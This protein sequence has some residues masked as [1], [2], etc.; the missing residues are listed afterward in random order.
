MREGDYA[1]STVG[2]LAA[3]SSRPRLDKIKA[4]PPPAK[5]ERQSALTLQPA[6]TADRSSN[7]L[8]PDTF[9]G[10]IGQVETVNLLRR[11]CETAHTRDEPLDHILFVGS[12]GTG[13]STFS[14]VIAHEMG[15]RCF[16]V[17]APV[18]LDLLTQLRTTMRDGD[19][20]RIEEIHMQAIQERRGKVA[21]AQPEVLFAVM[22]DR[23]LQT[24]T[25][26]LPFPHITVVGTT[27]DEGMLPDAF[28]NRFPLRPHLTP[29]DEDDL[30][31]IAMLN[32]EALGR[33]ITD[34]AAYMLARA[35]A[36]VPR[37]VNNFVKNASA[38]TD[39]G[40]DSTL[41]YEVIV[42][43][44]HTTLDGLT[45]DQQNMLTSLYQNGGLK[46]QAS[47]ATIAVWL[48]KS[49]DQKAV[50]LRVEPGLID[51]GYIGLGSR[52]RHLTDKGV[53]RARQLL[54]HSA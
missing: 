49:R 25:G 18:T 41:A 46:F 35:C 39:G 29:Y 8:R 9:S 13:K 34:E 4:T 15:V 28:I 10:V 26:I 7:P 33:E 42:K 3:I 14:H 20:L 45:L 24:P 36:G 12:S 47:I 50:Q 51:R 22:E 23:V 40:I 27:T 30:A 6:T 17:Q 48:G 32:A 19:I 5:P 54:E 52:G 38:L 37:H 21:S 16:E 44:N 11:V 53:Q 43:L 1:L 2:A 31:L